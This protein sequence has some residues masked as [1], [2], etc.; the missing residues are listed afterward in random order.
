M[1]T[2]HYPF[3]PVGQPKTLPLP[4]TTVYA[5]LSA[6][7]TRDPDHAAIDYYGARLS[8]AALKRQVEDRKSVV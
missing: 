7:A 5:N 3:W 2:R 8:Y 1:F 6:V 4:A